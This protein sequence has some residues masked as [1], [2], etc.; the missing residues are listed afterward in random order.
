[1]GNKLTTSYVLYHYVAFLYIIMLPFYIITV[2]TAG[3]NHQ[4]INM[5]ILYNVIIRNYQEIL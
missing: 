3:S 4:C 2:K 5:L 1:M